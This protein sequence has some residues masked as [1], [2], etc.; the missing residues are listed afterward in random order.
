MPFFYFSFQFS[1]GAGAGTGGCST[2]GCR[3]STT[4]KLEQMSFFI[5]HFNSLWEQGRERA[6]LQKGCMISTSLK[7]EQLTFF[8]SHFN[9]LWEQGRERAAA[10]LRGAGPLHWYQNRWPFYFSFQFSS[11]TGAGTDGCS[12]VGCRISTTPTPCSTSV[13]YLLW[14]SCWERSPCHLQMRWRGSYF[15]CLFC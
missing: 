10:L 15:N 5:S 8:I 13:A 12:T 14:R 2:A 11:G 3:T 9:S 4:L 6:A 1:L 7:P